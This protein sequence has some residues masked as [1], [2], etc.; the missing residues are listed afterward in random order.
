MSNHYH[1]LVCIDV[2]TANSWSNNEIIERWGK[3]YRIP[4]SVKQ[5][6]DG[7]DLNE[8]EQ[9][10]A[11]K[12]VEKWRQR[13]RDLSWYMRA[14]NEYIARRA[15]K[16]DKCKGKFFEARFKCQALLD[17]QAILT[18]MAYVDL[19]PIR[20]GF[21]STP[22]KSPFTSIRQR[23]HESLHSDANTQPIT[24]TG[25]HSKTP[26]LMP[27]RNSIKSLDTIPFSFSNDLELV[28]WTARRVLKNKSGSMNPSLP[29]IL[30]RA[31]INPEHWLSHMLLNGYNFVTAAGNQI[32]CDY[33]RN[34]PL[35]PKRD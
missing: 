8:H 23:I 22:E 15:N 25:T 18:C 5:L 19:N 14:F 26:A 9:K 32:V 30:A 4:L 33:L 31:G 6:H 24:L 12:L 7:C 21:A 3:I 13:L 35:T 28:D 27:F 11:I 10:G 34:I 16:E 1:L 20:A 17:D 29:P 2:D